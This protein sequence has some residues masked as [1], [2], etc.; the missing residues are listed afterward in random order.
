MAMLTYNLYFSLC[1][2]F[3]IYAKIVLTVLNVLIVEH[4]GNVNY[5]LQLKTLL[6]Y[7]FLKCNLF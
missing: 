3:W 4:Y 7:H 2:N 5:A 6:Y 1:F